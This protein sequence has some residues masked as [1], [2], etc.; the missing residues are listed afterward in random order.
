[1]SHLP[2]I[3][4]CPVNDFPSLADKSPHHSTEDALTLDPSRGCGEANS[5]IAA[6]TR[7]QSGEEVSQGATVI[8]AQLIGNSK[9]CLS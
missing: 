8:A 4:Y 1:V 3:N 9:G 5:A 2:A 6:R 7:L